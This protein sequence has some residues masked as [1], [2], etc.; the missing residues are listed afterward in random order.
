MKQ[1]VKWALTFELILF[2]ASKCRNIKRWVHFRLFKNK[3][4]FKNSI[5]N[6][7]CNLQLVSLRQVH[8]L[9][10][11]C[12]SITTHS[13][14]SLLILRV[15]SLVTSWMVLKRSQLRGFLIFETYQNQGDSCQDCMACVE[16][17]P[18][19]PFRCKSSSTI[20]LRAFFWLCISWCGTHL[21]ATFL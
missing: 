12:I 19:I 17:L 20:F 4:F 5:I 8:H 9:G 7:Q 14:L 1:V 10:K 21:A 2:P 6:L 18:L 13:L 3:I 16:E 15:T 11:S